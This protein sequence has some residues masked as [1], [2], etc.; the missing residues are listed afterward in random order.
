M[1][2]KFW[3]NNTSG[4]V[5]AEGYYGNNGATCEY[6]EPG[7]CLD[8]Y[9]LDGIINPIEIGDARV[10][11]EKVLNGRW[12]DSFQPWEIEEEEPGEY[13][14]GFTKVVTVHLEERYLGNSGW[15]IFQPTEQTF[16][17]VTMN[18]RWENGRIRLYQCEPPPYPPKPAEPPREVPPPVE[19]DWPLYAS[20]LDYFFGPPILLA[21]SR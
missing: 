18:M 6:N 17:D 10:R 12:W 19:E 20:V 14:D 8:E 16:K 11:L 15:W 1:G 7:D 9:K 2:G 5:I 4:K 21:R 13:P 3:I